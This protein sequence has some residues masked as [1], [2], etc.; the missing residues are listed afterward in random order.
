MMISSDDAVS[1]MLVETG[2]VAA[3]SVGG[4]A[5]TG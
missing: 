2:E 5:F 3:W 4:F 1:F